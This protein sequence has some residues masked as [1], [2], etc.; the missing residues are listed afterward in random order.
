MAHTDNELRDTLTTLTERWEQIAASAE[1]RADAA[2]NGTLSEVGHARAHTIRRL[3]RD[4]ADVLNTGR[5]PHDLM[6]TAELENHGKPA[7]ALRG[8]TR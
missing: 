6:T 8:G 7:A 2:A 4:V 1:A 5:I 3:A